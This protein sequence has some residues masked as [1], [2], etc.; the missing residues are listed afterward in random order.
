MLLD[1]FIVKSAGTYSILQYSL[2]VK[3]IQRPKEDSLYLQHLKRYLLQERK[4]TILN[5]RHV[6]DATCLKLSI[7]RS[8]TCYVQ[9]KYSSFCIFSWQSDTE[10]HTLSP[11]FPNA[12]VPPLLLVHGLKVGAPYCNYMNFMLM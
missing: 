6:A 10:N 3:W 5:A 9:N 8:P 4:A 11:P 7:M 2:V 1:N 12:M